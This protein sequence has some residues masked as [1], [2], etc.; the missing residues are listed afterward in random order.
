MRESMVL[1]E[2]VIGFELSGS[3]KQFK[4]PVSDN[5]KKPKDTEDDDDESNDEMSTLQTIFVV[6]SVCL[7]LSL[8]IL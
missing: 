1:D 3:K 2:K 4:W 7:V 5:D 6:H 8:K